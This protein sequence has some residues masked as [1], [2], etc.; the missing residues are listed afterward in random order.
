MIKKTYNLWMV[1]KIWKVKTPTTFRFFLWFGRWVG[2]ISWM[3]WKLLEWY[4]INYFPNEIQQ[5]KIAESIHQIQFISWSRVRDELPTQFGSLPYQS[6][7][8]EC[9]WG[10]WKPPWGVYDQGVSP[11]PNQV[12]GLIS[13]DWI[14][15]HFFF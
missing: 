10:T 15:R 3:P 9:V 6:G 13:S 2:P 1:E 4:A 8:V 7:G 5:H 14:P 12:G 11:Q